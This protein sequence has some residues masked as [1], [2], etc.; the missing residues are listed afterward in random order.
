MKINFKGK[1]FLLVLFLHIPGQSKG[2]GDKHICIFIYILCALISDYLHSVLQITII[3]ILHRLFTK[4]TRNPYSSEN[5]SSIFWQTF[6]FKKFSM[7]PLPSSLF[8]WDLPWGPKHLSQGT[9]ERSW[10]CVSH[11][12]GG[13]NNSKFCWCYLP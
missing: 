2:G 12:R 1:I 13:W 8:S 11:R 10:C 6:F 9:P 7:V 3:N 5:Y 4:M